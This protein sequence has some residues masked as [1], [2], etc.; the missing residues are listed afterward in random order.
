MTPASA[1]ARPALRAAHRAEGDPRREEQAKKI[2][3]RAC[4]D[5]DDLVHNAAQDAPGAGAFALT[6][7]K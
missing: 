3:R 1:L 2:V 6:E 5:L 7:E 4:E